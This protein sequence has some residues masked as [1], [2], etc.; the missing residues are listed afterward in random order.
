M[1][2]IKT[3]IDK[4]FDNNKGDAGRV[5]HGR[6][7][8]FP[9]LE[10]IVI[11][12]YPPVILIT[13]YKIYEPVE[14]LVDFLRSLNHANIVIQ[15]R[16]ISQTPYEI[17]SGEIPEN[18]VVEEGGCRYSINLKHAQNAGLFL[19]MVN[20]R[21]WLKE[22]STGKRVL[23]LFSYTC[24]L[25]VAA[26]QGNACHVVNI[27]MSRSAL[28]KGRENHRLNSFDMG[29]VEFFAYDILK[30]WSRIKKKGPYDLIVI[31]PPTLQKGSF[32]ASKDYIKIVRR[33]P[34]L[35]N[36]G[37]QVLAVLNSPDL[38]TNFMKKLFAEEYRQASFVERLENPASFPEKDL[39]KA[40]KVLL[41]ES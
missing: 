37:G 18:H 4:F 19:D 15:R 21:Q 36:N 31:D 22:N 16:Y 39:E 20:G 11:D 41:F 32:I 28:N 9:G 27:D 10:N 24:S 17:V 8:C 14:E 40:L 3:H 30:S 35:M 25:S 38:D 34:Q 26:L 2:Q 7:N 6:G 33:L 5:F 29:R 12:Y 23:N 13:L 1:Q